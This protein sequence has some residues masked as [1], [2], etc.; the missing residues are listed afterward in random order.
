MNKIP[1]I[2]HQV[3]SETYQPLPEQFKIFSETWKEHYPDWEYILWDNK[4]M[5]EFVQKSYPHYWNIFNNYPYD[6]QRW[7][8]IRYLILDKIGG[9][10]VDFDYESIS[11]IDK[12][13]EDKTCCFSLE[14]KSHINAF[15]RE[16]DDV[17]NNALMLNTPGHPFMHKIVETVFSE[18]MLHY[19]APKNICVYNTTGPWILIDLYYDLTEEEKKQV[20]LIPAEY[21]TPFDLPQANRLRRGEQ[22]EELENCLEEAYAV[23]YFWGNWKK[24]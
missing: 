21:V 3:W 19:D 14:P 22:S 16:V 24:E 2:I 13:I 4:K 18:S 20:Y 7:D 23:H 6:V 17:F 10:Y 5:N 1:K 15:K 8:A 12:L 9:M 11:P